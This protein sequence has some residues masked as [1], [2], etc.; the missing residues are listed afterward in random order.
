MQTPPG[1]RRR[2]PWRRPQPWR[3]WRAGRPQPRRPPGRCPPAEERGQKGSSSTGCISCPATQLGPAIALHSS[4]S[5]S[6][7]AS[8]WRSSRRAAC[9]CCGGFCRRGRP[10]PPSDPRSAPAAACPA[11]LHTTE[12]GAASGQARASAPKGEHFQG[13]PAATRQLQQQRRQCA[14]A[15]RRPPP[16]ATVVAVVAASAEA[17]LGAASLASPP[18]QAGRAAGWAALIRGVWWH[19]GRAPMPTLN[20]SQACPLRRALHLCTLS[21]S[22]A[23]TPMPSTPPAWTPFCSGQRRRGEQHRRGAV[24]EGPPLPRGQCSAARPPPAAL[25]C[26]MCA[27]TRATLR[28]TGSLLGSNS[29]RW[30]CGSAGVR[31]KGRRSAVRPPNAAVAARHT[32]AVQEAHTML[33]DLICRGGCRGLGLLGKKE[34]PHLGAGTGAA[35]RSGARRE[36]HTAASRSGAEPCNRRCSRAQCSERKPSIAER[37]ASRGRCSRAASVE[38]PTASPL[39]K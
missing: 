9:A 38:Q 21:T 14:T 32:L 26:T 36:L 7:P 18:W 15:S 28:A 10:H 6:L 24:W 4:L 33:L 39:K 5:L 8:H 27:I 20:G 25:A 1:R 34:R 23:T 13:S 2:P 16:R 30:L 12:Q 35:R 19:S 17:T 11:P 37:R 22:G 3:L 31:C 29:C